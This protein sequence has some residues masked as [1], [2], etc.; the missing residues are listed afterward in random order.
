MS[1]QPATQ[2]PRASTGPVS[3]QQ[4]PSSSSSSSSSAAAAAAAVAAGSSA[5]VV[6]DCSPAPQR[7]A[8]FQCR[9]IVHHLAQRVDSQQRVVHNLRERSSIIVKAL[10]YITGDGDKVDPLILPPAQV[11]YLRFQDSGSAAASHRADGKDRR[12]R[13]ASGRAGSCNADSLGIAEGAFVRGRRPSVS[14]RVRGRGGSGGG[15]RHELDGKG[16]DSCDIDGEAGTLS[17]RTNAL[18]FEPFALS[19]SLS[20]STSRSVAG[21]RHSLPPRH[22]MPPRYSQ[23]QQLLYIPL[24]QIHRIGRLAGG[25]KI[26]TSKQAYCFH[27]G[28]GGAGGSGTPR[29]RTNSSFNRG[30]G[31]EVGARSN[32]V[33]GANPEQQLSGEAELIRVWRQC[34]GL[35]LTSAKHASERSRLQATRRAIVCSGVGGSRTGG[36]SPTVNAFSLASHPVLKKQQELV[37]K[38]SLAMQAAIDHLRAVAL[39][40]REV[41]ELVGTCHEILKPSATE[42][43]KTLLGGLLGENGDGRASPWGGAAVASPTATIQRSVSSDASGASHAESPIRTKKGSSSAPSSPSSGHHFSIS[44][45]SAMAANRGRSPKQEPLFPHELPKSP[46]DGLL[47]EMVALTNDGTQPSPE[48]S[49][50][51]SVASAEPPLLPLTA[52]LNRRFQ[53]LSPQVQFHNVFVRLCHILQLPEAKDICDEIDTFVRTVKLC[54]PPPPNAQE[55]EVPAIHERSRSANMPVFPERKVSA[56]R[57]RSSSVR[58][59]SPGRAQPRRSLSKDSDGGVDARHRARSHSRKQFRLSRGKSAPEYDDTGMGVLGGT[60]ATLRAQNRRRTLSAASENSGESVGAFQVS[61]L[62]TAQDV[63]LAATSRVRRG[64]SESPGVQPEDTAVGDAVPTLRLDEPAL[65]SDAECSNPQGFAKGTARTQ[66]PGAF[67]RNLYA[68]PGHDAWSPSNLLALSLLE[69]EQRQARQNQQRDK[70]EDQLAQ[71]GN[72]E[73]PSRRRKPDLAAQQPALTANAPTQA[74]PRHTSSH[75]PMRRGARGHSLGPND[76]LKYRSPRGSSSAPTTPVDERAKRKGFIGSARRR[77]PALQTPT[78]KPSLAATVFD[79]VQSREERVARFLDILSDRIFYHPAFQDL[80]PMWQE[81]MRDGFEKIV[82]DR[83]RAVLLEPLHLVPEWM[84]K[85]RLLQQRCRALCSVLEPRHLDLSMVDLFSLGFPEDDFLSSSCQ[86]RSKDSDSDSATRNLSSPPTSSLLLSPSSVSERSA[87]SEGSLYTKDPSNSSP[88]PRA[89]SFCPPPLVLQI[90]ATELR[91]IAALSSPNE[92]LLQVNK[93]FEMVTRATL[94]AAQAATPPGQK[95]DASGADD[96]LPVFIL[97][98]IRAAA[99]METL[100]SLIHFVSQYFN[101]HSLSSRLEYSFAMLQ[102]GVGFLQEIEGSVLSLRPGENFDELLQSEEE[103][104]FLEAKKERKAATEVRCTGSQQALIV[105]RHVFESRGH[106]A[107]PEC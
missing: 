19:S 93:T 60:V 46:G 85:N 34:C 99:K 80:P 106:E 4:E 70:E 40:L 84:V 50:S 69:Q 91:K 78:R 97:V 51:K 26:I 102:S 88:S 76:R 72:A 57:G 61:P 89:V 38:T 22:S 23:V 32:T 100:A 24:N 21:S 14:A 101:Q 12:P 87:N 41:H 68:V 58:A 63:T 31:A 18:I 107:S 95:R 37:I 47:A 56:N 2:I 96:L 65:S 83:L 7:P 73:P 64:V 92:I 77:G 11:T 15:A 81:R 20:S 25:L 55:E 86:R 48:V 42:R 71:I 10:W 39:T 45:D 13:S 9:D 79:E 53:T 66:A 35:A 67:L 43:I 105:Q 98:I 94:S 17:L 6:A 82:M 49:G 36:D 90:I 33:L 62:L 8:L 1:A 74:P 44:T 54:Y 104:I 30:S 75:N 3:S 16:D 59:D 52:E 103:C 27:F 28:C 29:M 5:A